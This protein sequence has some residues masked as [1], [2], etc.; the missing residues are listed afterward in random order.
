MEALQEKRVGKQMEGRCGLSNNILKRSI[1]ASWN[2][3]S[4]TLGKIKSSTSH[5]NTNGKIWKESCAG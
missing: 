5:L 4:M 2:E 1:S 3:D